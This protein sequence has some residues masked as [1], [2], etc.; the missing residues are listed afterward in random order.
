MSAVG[1]V[2]VRSADNALA[3][4]RLTRPTVVRERPNA[5]LRREF[6]C[7]MRIRRRQAAVAVTAVERRRCRVRLARRLFAASHRM[8]PPSLGGVPD[9]Y[10]T[11]A[12]AP[13]RSSL[14]RLSRGG[15]VSDLPSRDEQTQWD[16]RLLETGKA[17]HR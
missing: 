4:S 2:S 5:P 9:R 6:L 13:S 8:L 11:R 10:S 17:G 1:I 3:G 12:L 7:R 16:S 14:G 15:R